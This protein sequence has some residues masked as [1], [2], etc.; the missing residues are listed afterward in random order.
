[1]AQA[2]SGGKR[3]GEGTR[4]GV[5]PV[6]AVERAGKV[7]EVLLAAPP[8]GLP[9]AEIAEQTGLHKTTALRLLRSLT[10]IRV[11]RRLSGTDRYAWDALHWLGVAMKVRA[12]VSRADTVQALVEALAVR[13]GETVGLGYG[14]IAKREVLF[15]AVGTSKNLLRVDL[16]ETRSF[17]LH[18]CASGKMCLAHM[19][20]AE[21][22]E[23]AAK[24]LPAMTART[25]TSLPKLLEELARVRKQGYAIAREEGLVGVVGVAV[26]LRD[27]A[28]GV[29][30]ALSLI[31][32]AQRATDEA[33]KQWIRLLQDAS[34]EIT[35]LLYAAGGG[36]VGAQAEAADPRPQ[37]ASSGGPRTAGGEHT[38]KAYRVV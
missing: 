10:S 30:A 12:T 27:D 20:E 29:V 37:E 7:L 6:R 34:G 23:F 24:G 2:S 26:P 15:V 36:E 13:S 19:P 38:R 1:M 14:N 9:L 8:E 31:A 33:L 16:G 4:K 22:R 35:R 32:P 25:I 17:P 5:A 21:V 11:V 28:G 3:A 18:A